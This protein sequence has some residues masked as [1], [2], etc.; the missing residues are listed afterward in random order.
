M[1]KKIKSTFLTMSLVLFVVALVASSL[2][3]LVYKVTKEPIEKAEQDKKEKAIKIVVPEF[4]N[5]PFKE[6]YKIAS[7]DGD[8]LTCFPAKK[9]D[10]I[11]GIAIETY[12]DRGFTGKFT[13]MVGFLPDGTIYNSAVLSHQETPGLGDKMS[14][15]KSDWCEQFYE[16]NVPEIND[17]DNDGILIEVTKD[18]GE[19]D[20]ITA[21]TISSRA[22]CDALERAY[23]AYMNQK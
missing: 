7:L 16:L 21:A 20:A 9:G 6:V 1:A 22:Y 19:V 3:S 8:S 17:K 18:G 11:V 4:D 12:T 15:T 2:L 14:I 5:S 13:V 23:N 10:E